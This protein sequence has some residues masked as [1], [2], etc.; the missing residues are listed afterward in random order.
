VLLWSADDPPSSYAL[1]RP[2]FGHDTYLPLLHR[3][4]S[5]GHIDPHLDLS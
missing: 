5:V 2:V 1:H 3:P 4:V